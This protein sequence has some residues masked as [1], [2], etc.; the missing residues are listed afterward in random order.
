MQAQRVLL[1][2]G[3]V[4]AYKGLNVLLDAMAQIDEKT[5]THLLV[6]GEFYDDERKYRA[7][8]A[9]LRLEQRVT[10]V[11]DYVPNDKV[12]LYFSAAD[13]V[14]LPYLSATQSGIAQIAYNFD[15]PV[16]ATNVGGLSEVVLDGAS[17]FLVPPGDA[18]SL[19]HSIRRYYDENRRDEFVTTVRKE[20]HKYSWQNLVGSIEEL[21]AG[22]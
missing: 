6:V 14:V 9:A 2:F 10:L 22:R 15:L 11:S 13:V 20:K 19:A 21:V 18:K 4:R 16:I 12:H 7:Q 17:G 1:F 5:D 8:I 3:Y